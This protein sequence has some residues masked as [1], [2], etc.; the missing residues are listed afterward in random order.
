MKKL[1]MLA[2]VSAAAF[3]AV[4]AAANAQFYAGAGYTHFDSDAGDLGGVTL[5][6][7]YRLNQNFAV[8]GEGTL[9]IEDDGAV[10]LNHNLGAYAVGILPVSS[11]FD[12]HARVG[13][14]QTEFDTPLGSVDS[15]GVGYGVGGTYRFTPNLGIRGDFTRFDGD[16][17][18]DTISLGAVVSF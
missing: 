6:G 10:E 5:R 11:A 18:S 9:G 2:A 8:E 16:I 1:A 13:W 14:Q 7:G 17:E 15:D 12:L 3:F 4:P